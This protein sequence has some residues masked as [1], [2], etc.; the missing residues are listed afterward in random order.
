MEK[1]PTYT[2]NGKD[3]SGGKFIDAS[4]EFTLPGPPT[5]PGPV[6]GAGAP[7]SKAAFEEMKARY[8]NVKGKNDTEWITF[9]REAILTILAQNDCAGIKFYFVER[10]E[11]TS[12][13]LTLTMAGVDANNN[14]LTTANGGQ[15]LLSDGGGT[16]YTDSGNGHPPS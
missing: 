2:A 4:L 3:Y 6:Q 8:L 1:K 7:V 15:A 13:Q 12:H 14:D 11:T 5:N 10:M 16:L 9:S